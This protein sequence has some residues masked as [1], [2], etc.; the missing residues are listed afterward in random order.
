[1]EIQI[2]DSFSPNCDCRPYKP[3]VW[4]RNVETVF[5]YT[6]AYGMLYAVLPH[7]VETG[8]IFSCLNYCLMLL[9]DFLVMQVGNI[10][11]SQDFVRNAEYVF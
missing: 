6:R 8:H 4:Y 10:W 7:Q 5:D 9:I 1:M 3:V 2:R 11:I